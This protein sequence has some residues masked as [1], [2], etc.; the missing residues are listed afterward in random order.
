[1]IE[2]RF[3]LAREVRARVGVARVANH[4]ASRSTK[5]A[6]VHVVHRLFDVKT[7]TFT[8]TFR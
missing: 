5:I 8:I 2:G 6:R 4:S 7:G 3:Q 1:M